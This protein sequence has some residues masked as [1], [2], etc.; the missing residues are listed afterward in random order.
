MSIINFEW[1]KGSSWLM[2]INAV[3]LQLFYCFRSKGY[4]FVMFTKHE[5]ALAC[6][7]RMNN[8]PSLFDKN[9]V[10]FIIELN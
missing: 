8:N 1:F 9:N 2:K 10:R 7:R 4:G 3:I 5:D 6:L